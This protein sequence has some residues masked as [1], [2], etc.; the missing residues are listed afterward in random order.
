MAFLPKTKSSHSHYPFLFKK[1]KQ[2]PPLFKKTPPRSGLPRQ[3]HRLRPIY[4][5]HPE[6]TRTKTILNLLEF[7]FKIYTSTCRCKKKE[8]YMWEDRYSSVSL[9]SISQ[10]PLWHSFWEGLH[11]KQHRASFK[12]YISIYNI[13]WVSQW[14]ICLVKS[15]NDTLGQRALKEKQDTPTHQ[16]L[17]FLYVQSFGPLW[18]IKDYDLIW[19]A[20]E[21]ASHFPRIFK[22]VLEVDVCAGVCVRWIDCN[23]MQRQSKLIVMSVWWSLT[24][25]HI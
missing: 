21:K 24:S 13:S 8:G 11:Q 10:G 23:I 5:M 3:I 1:G 22:P 12:S 14:M 16:I 25:G 4:T 20:I 18:R 15:S 17:S 19:F 2:W 6:K 9:R 7:P